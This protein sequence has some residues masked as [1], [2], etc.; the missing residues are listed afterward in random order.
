MIGLSY[1]YN[2]RQIPQQVNIYN[3]TSEFGDPLPP[4]TSNFLKQEG[5]T[6]DLILQE[7]GSR[8]LITA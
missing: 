2:K 4:P 5:A 8:I 7:D 6:F 1:F 3:P